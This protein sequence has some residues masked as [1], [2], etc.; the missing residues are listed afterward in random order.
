M[1]TKLRFHFH[2]WFY[3][4]VSGHAHYHLQRRCVR[5]GCNKRQYMSEKNNRWIN[6]MYREK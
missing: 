6:A 3:S 1:N 5:N 2:K 4:K